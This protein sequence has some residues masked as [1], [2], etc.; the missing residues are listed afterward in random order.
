M[1]VHLRP[2]PFQELPDN[3]R[4][5][6][7]LRSID[8]KKEKPREREPVSMEPILELKDVALSYKKRQILKQINL[9]A[10]PGEI[11]AVVGHNGTGKTTFSRSPVR[12]A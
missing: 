9:K 11:I 3:K 6:M 10:A 1:R 12:L 4:K 2:Q 5:A 8:L 7:G